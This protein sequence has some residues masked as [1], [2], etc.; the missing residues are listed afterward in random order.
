MASPETVTF[1]TDCFNTVMET[2]RRKTSDRN[3]LVNKTLRHIWLAGYWSRP[4][5][6]ASYDCPLP[7]HCA[8]VPPELLHSATELSLLMQRVG[9]LPP[10]LR[11]TIVGYSC[12]SLVWRLVAASTWHLSIFG[13][14]R[15]TIPRTIPLKDLGSLWIRGSPAQGSLTE[16]QGNRVRITLDCDGIKAVEV[17]AHRDPLAEK[18][19]CGSW[20]ILEDVSQIGNLCLSSEVG[21]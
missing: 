5:T 9:S 15:D 7:R 2:V 11:D 6:K 3:G 10:E 17:L 20:Y 14:L 13:R 8:V 12:Y 4:W 21:P 16:S 1:H 19:A 18:R